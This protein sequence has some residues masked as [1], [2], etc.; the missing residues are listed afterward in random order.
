MNDVTLTP[1][2]ALAE[3]VIEATRTAGHLDLAPARRASALS[4]LETL[5]YPTTRD[6][7]WKYTRV[8]RIQQLELSSA[9]AASASAPSVLPELDA[10]RLV[11]VDGQFA[12]GD[13]LNASGIFL[14]PLSH[15]VVDCPNRLGALESDH[16]SGTEWFAALQAAAPQDGAAV[17]V[18]DGATFDK[19]VLIH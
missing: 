18:P 6:E 5:H 15:A 17:L 2:S 1:A 14:G 11:F 16:F 12:G 3:R 19:P 4:A 10:H 13:A 8:A 9:P 7:R